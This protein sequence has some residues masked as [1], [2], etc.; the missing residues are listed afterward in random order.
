MRKRRQQ[1]VPLDSAEAVK[2]IKEMQETQ[3]DNW[4]LE[5]IK[6]ATAQLSEC[7]RLI[8]FLYAFEG[9]THAEIAKKLNISVITSRT[10]YHRAK[11]KLKALLYNDKILLRI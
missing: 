7:H 5:K 1:N 3:E 11:K 2:E 4:Q 8:L 6:R 10:Q 9:F